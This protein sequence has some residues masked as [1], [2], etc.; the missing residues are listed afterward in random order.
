MKL[1]RFVHLLQERTQSKEYKM[2]GVLTVDLH[3]KNP[4]RIAVLKRLLEQML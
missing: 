4:P 3:G 1:V 2:C